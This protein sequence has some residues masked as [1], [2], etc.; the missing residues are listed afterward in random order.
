MKLSVRMRAAILGNVVVLLLFPWQC[1][2]AYAD[3]AIFPLISATTTMARLRILPQTSIP[4]SVAVS[5]QP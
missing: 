5:C 2:I 4:R 1:F 3:D